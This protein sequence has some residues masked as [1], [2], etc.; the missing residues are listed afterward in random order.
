MR[1]GDPN[2]GWAFKLDRR[3]YDGHNRKAGSGARGKQ[4]SHRKKRRNFR[5]FARRIV[6]EGFAKMIGA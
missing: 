4:L 6:G 5:R 3:L 2:N 1:A